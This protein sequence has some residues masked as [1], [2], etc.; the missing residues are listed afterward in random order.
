MNFEIVAGKQENNLV[1][2]EN[3]QFYKT[4]VVKYLS[5]YK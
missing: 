5:V 2:Y 1:L 3:E 4:T